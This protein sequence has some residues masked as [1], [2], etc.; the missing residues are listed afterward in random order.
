MMCP[1]AI[2][3]WIFQQADKD[4]S[5]KELE[6]K[7]LSIV[8]NRVS[9]TATPMDIGAMGK[10]R[11]HQGCDHGQGNHEDMC[12]HHGAQEGQN[13]FE[14]LAVGQGTQCYKCKG[15]GHMA[16]VCA[17]KVMGKEEKE[18]EKEDLE[19]MAEKVL[20]VAEKVLEKT[21]ENVLAK[22]RGKGSK[23]N[24]SNAERKDT[25]H[26]NIEA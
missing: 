3:E 14:V 26:S 20:Q 1:T 23:A 13:E 17:T 4:T 24:A 25:E 8:S 2:Q 10:G 15:W 11:E 6:A 7:M 18:K 21:K 19:D 9:M 22:E 12:H 16:R 5:Y